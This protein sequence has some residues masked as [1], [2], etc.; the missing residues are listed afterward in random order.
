MDATFRKK[1]EEYKKRLFQEL[2]RRINKRF[3]KSL[4]PKRPVPMMTVANIQYELADHVHGLSIGG[5]D[6]TLLLARRIGDD[7]DFF[8]ASLF[9]YRSATEAASPRRPGPTQDR[10]PPGHRSHELAPFTPEAVNVGFFHHHI[11]LCPR[12]GHG[13]QAVLWSEARVIQQVDINEVPMS[14]QDPGG[15]PCCQKLYEAPLPPE[16]KPGGSVGPNLTTLIAYLKRG[17]LSRFGLPPKIGPS[18]NGSP[19]VE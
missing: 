8:Q 9:R 19:R 15:C 11:D 16:I 2:R 7:I 18:R 14:I 6:G 5:I 17:P 13:L 12:C 1:R 3:A 10:W 4:G